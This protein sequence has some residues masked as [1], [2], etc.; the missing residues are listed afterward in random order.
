[1]N[2]PFGYGLSYTDFEIKT[3]DVTVDG[4]S[5]TVKA[6]VTNVGATAS[7]KEVAE[8]YF[9]APAGSLDKPYQE[10]G[11]V[12][13]DRHPQARPAPEVTIRFNTADL[14]SYNT[15]KAAY[16]MEAG[17]YLIRVGNS[18]RNTHVKS[19]FAS[20]PMWSPSNCPP[21]TT[22]HPCQRTRLGAENYYS[23]ATEADRSRR[24][25]ATLAPAAIRHQN[26]A[27]DSLR[28]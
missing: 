1:M 19:K 10:L 21:R 14:A 5:V 26:N 8:V 2:Y 22:T 16:L 25:P 11:R 13:E 3:Q 4:T 17:D 24:H 23:Y 9:S 28:T 6:K 20:P 15:A 12:R 27:S 7:G 18:S